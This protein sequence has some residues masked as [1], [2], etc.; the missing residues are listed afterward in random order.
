MVGCGACVDKNA[1]GPEE[2]D[3]AAGPLPL[4]LPPSLGHSR[5][6]WPISPHS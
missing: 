1:A 2:L 5:L 6:K 3:A 4:P